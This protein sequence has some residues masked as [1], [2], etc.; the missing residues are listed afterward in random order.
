VGSFAN[1]HPLVA[2][3]LEAACARCFGVQIGDQLAEDPCLI[4]IADAAIAALDD[5]LGDDPPPREVP[6]PSLAEFA[7]VN[8]YRRLVGDGGDLV[9]DGEN[10]S[11]PF[12]RATSR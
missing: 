12:S 3:V 10:P 7:L 6:E 4:G 11:N 1:S 8:G 2:H 9:R 5:R